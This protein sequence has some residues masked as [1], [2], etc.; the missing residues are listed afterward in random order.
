MKQV[1]IETRNGFPINSDAMA[2][3]DGFE[4]LVIEII[5]ERENAD[6]QENNS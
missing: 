6:K 3:V 5:A 4:Y 2:A 1:F